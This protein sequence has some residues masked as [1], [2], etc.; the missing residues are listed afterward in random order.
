MTQLLKSPPT[1]QPTVLPKKIRPPQPSLKKLGLWMLFW[2][3]LMDVG[4]NVLFPFPKDPT[5]TPN[6]LTRYF[7]YGRSIEDKLNRMVQDTVE[8]SD[9]II[10]AGWISPDDW[11]GLPET[12]K[13]GDDLLIA[14]YGMSFSNDIVRALKDIDDN[15]TVRSIG[16][17]SAPPNHTF[18]AFQA[19]KANQQADVVIFGVLASS[20]MRMNSLSGMHWT[21]ENPTPYTYPY[22]SLNSQNELEATMPV[23]S[24]GDAFV[25]AF[26]RKDE[27]WKQLKAQ[28]RQHDQAFDSFIFYHNL[29]DR[30]A[31][32][33]LIR[34]GWASRQRHRVETDFFDPVTG[35]NPEAP[36]IKTLKVMLEEFVAQAK[37]AEQTPVILLI[38]N[39][40]YSDSLYQ[41]LA[42][43]V[44]SLDAQV[45]S[46][47]E[48]V[49]PDDPGNF[50]ADSH[51]IPEAN[52]KLAE[53]LKL[54]IRGE[55]SSTSNTSNTDESLD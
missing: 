31:I 32:V 40:G 9:R 27:R 49:S 37:A 4:I 44:N 3:V 22:Y 12:P 53:A 51:Y 52:R 41:V 24:S 17:P 48:V 6:S 55:H 10:G 54:K 33:R 8:N 5:Q 14:E 42:S 35:F 29:T 18:A 15:I 7:N 34:R 1:A 45:F 38:N 2:L 23:I 20:V 16:G 30:S 21:Y 43:H 39:Q 46:T 11:K 47:H 25:E 36:T 26:N 50:L 19:D 13:A 28:M